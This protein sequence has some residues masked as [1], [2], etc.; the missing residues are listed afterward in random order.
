MTTTRRLK[1]PHTPGIDTTA[2][3][4]ARCARRTGRAAGFALLCAPLAFVASAQQA[5]APALGD[6]R[7]LGLNVGATWS[8][9][10]ARAPD[11]QPAQEDGW[12][13]ASILANLRKNSP[14]LEGTLDANV[15]YRTYTDSTFEDQVI[16][17]F[18]LYGRAYIVP[19]YFSWV[20]EDNFGQG[21]VNAFAVESPENSQ[22]V[23]YL[24]TGPD[25]FF[26]VGDR[27]RVVLGARYGKTSYEDTPNDND[28]RLVSLSFERRIARPTVLRLT[29]GT[30]KVE[31]AESPVNTDYDVH[32]L[33]VGITATGVKT[34]IDAEAGYSILDD[35]VDKDHGTVARFVMTRRM[36]ARQNASVTLGSE[37]SDSGGLFR[38]G[39]L[40]QG[41]GPQNGNAIVGGDPLRA[42]YLFAAWTASGVRMSMRLSVDLRKE[43][44]ETQTTLD[45]KRT[46]FGAE[47][48]YRLTP[49]VGIRLNG[50]Y[51]KDKFDVVD[52]QVDEKAYGGGLTWHLNSRLTLAL[53]YEHS[54][55][56]SGI[57][58]NEFQENRY[59]AN[60]GYTRSR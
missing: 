26:P 40:A 13:D 52:T 44:H 14:R 48:E 2:Q 27:S 18:N 17:G 4:A 1:T 20:L 8:D 6:G 12:V 28:R 49:R 42:D 24:S 38:V 31:F 35:G 36:T 59:T 50:E 23:N 60:L 30:E 34:T 3:G 25:I 45:V 32:E 16:G 53:L 58:G 47:T 33:T 51:R 41:A 11:T 22:S 21:S 29:A 19:A 7:S 15:G 56:S 9:N 55:G 57:G 43:S 5:A 46:S 37:F 39:Q 10:L 54:D